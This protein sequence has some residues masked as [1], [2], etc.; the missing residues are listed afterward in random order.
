MQFEIAEK[1]FYIQSFVKSALYISITDNNLMVDLPLFKD[2]FFLTEPQI[3]VV[4][5]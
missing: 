4:T 2:T 1:T 3:S 5:Y